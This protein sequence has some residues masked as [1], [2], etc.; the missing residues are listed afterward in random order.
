[1]TASAGERR[2]SSRPVQPPQAPPRYAARS[3][4]ALLGPMASRCAPHRCRSLLTPFGESISLRGGNPSLTGCWKV[5][6]EVLVDD[7][8]VSK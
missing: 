3:R 6:G 7:L 1:M 8:D 4:I 2:P 5:C